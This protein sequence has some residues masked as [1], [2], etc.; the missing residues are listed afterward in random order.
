LTKEINREVIAR[1]RGFTLVG[2]E[3]ELALLH[4]A[5]SSPPAVV[6]VEG[7]A[8]VGKSRLVHETADAARCQKTQRDLGLMRPKPRGRR[9]Y[10]QELSPREIEVARLLA[11]EASN[12]D[13]ARALGLSPRTVEH[14]VGRVLKKL[15]VARE[16]LQR[17]SLP[18]DFE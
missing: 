5:L 16:D 2:R 10:G 13:I 15:G 14:H 9:G 3:R 7:E 4:A 11:D 1:D 17:D 6:L 18:A 8:G 12:Q